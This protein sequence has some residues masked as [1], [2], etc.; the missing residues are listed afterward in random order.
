[1]IKGHFDK[2]WADEQQKI[3]EELQDELPDILP[4]QCF[5]NTYGDGFD[6]KPLAEPS[7]FCH[8]SSAGAEGGMI[9]GNY[10]T[11]KGEGDDACTYSTMPSETISI[12]M[13][14]TK[15]DVPI[16]SCKVESRYVKARSVVSFRPAVCKKMY[17][18]GHGTEIKHGHILILNFLIQLWRRTLLHL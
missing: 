9:R 14:T 11:M 18:G 15:P 3:L 1:M 16:T 12:T 10:P 13:M 4:P 5:R 2:K 17:E 8:C 7:A 6:G